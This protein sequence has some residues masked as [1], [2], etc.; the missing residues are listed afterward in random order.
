MLAFP[1]LLP[2]PGIPCPEKD[3][4]IYLLPGTGA[5]CRLFDKLDFP[6]DTVHLEFPMPEKKMS[7]R[8]YALSFIPRIDTDRD[9]ILIGVSLGGMICTELSDTLSPGRVII[10]SSAKERAELPHRYRFQKFLPLNQAL[11]AGIIHRGSRLVAPLVE[12]ERKADTLFRSMI[13]KKD[14]QYLKWAVNMIIDW[15]RKGY[16]SSIVHIHGDRDHTLPIRKVACDHPVPGGTHMMVWF[17][18]DEINKLINEIF[19]E[20][21]EGMHL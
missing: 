17:S 11:P 6:F 8:D 4:V 1:I 12:P 20:Y 13:T 9:F 2:D 15:D 7:L 14:P 21:A 10:I 3:P 16:D 5:D 19:M 18:A